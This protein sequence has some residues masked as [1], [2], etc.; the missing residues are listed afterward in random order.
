MRFAK[1]SIPQ[2]Q[3]SSANELANASSPRT[4]TSRTGFL[5]QSPVTPK[6]GS[7]RHRRL[8][9]FSPILAGATLRER[10]VA[11]VGALVSIGLTGVIS[12][13]LFG[14]GPPSSAHRGPQG[15]VGGPSLRG[16][17]KSACAAVVDHR[18]AIRFRR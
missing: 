18:R 13:Y 10:L 14:Q 11:C 12:G 6:V 8:R 15:A 17:G 1:S 7:N 3:G 16:T 4:I 9:L 2:R 5:M